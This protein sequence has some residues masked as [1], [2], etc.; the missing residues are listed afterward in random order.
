MFKIGA[1]DTDAA[2]MS[3]TAVTPMTETPTLQPHPET[4][5]PATPPGT[6]VDSEVPRLGGG[7]LTTPAP[8]GTPDSSHE[9]TDI[10]TAPAAEFIPTLPDSVPVLPSATAQIV[11]PPAA[12]E[13]K[14]AEER[15]ALNA[16]QFDSASLPTLP[17]AGPAAPV[18]VEDVEPETTGQQSSADGTAEH[19]MAH[20][21]PSKSKPTQASIQAAEQRAIKKAKA[22]KIKIGVFIG[23]LAVSALA[24]PPLYSWFSNALAEAGDTST[25]TDE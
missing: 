18:M 1:P 22:K 5:V 15:F 8:I 17:E 14:N 3:D 19:P 16:M 25:T 6:T 24:G 12:P 13:P 7:P 4:A 2:A 11:S 21:M 23:A 20:L 9:A 10:S